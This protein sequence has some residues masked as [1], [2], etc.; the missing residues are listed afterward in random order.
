MKKELEAAVKNAAIR[1]FGRIFYALLSEIGND[2]LKYAL[3]R[4]DFP[5]VT[6]HN[7]NEITPEESLTK[8]AQSIETVIDGLVDEV[9]TKFILVDK[10]DVVNIPFK[11][12]LKKMEAQDFT[13]ARDHAIKNWLND[14]GSPCELFEAVKNIFEA[15]YA[16][17]YLKLATKETSEKG[18]NFLALMDTLSDKAA[19]QA[20]ATILELSRNAP[21]A[22]FKIFAKT[23]IDELIKVYRGKNKMAALNKTNKVVFSAFINHR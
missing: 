20:L 1:N 10:E 23:F 21:Y 6:V 2:S 12:E 4:H 17:T 22:P 15:M 14:K 18:T 16:Q 19:R 9:R 5:V 3:E 11:K 7:I 13:A 8:L